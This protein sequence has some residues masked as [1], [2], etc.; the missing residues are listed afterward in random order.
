MKFYNILNLL[1]PRNRP[2]PSVSDSL[3]VY[4]VC[5]SIVVLSGSLSVRSY[6]FLTIL[7]QF[8]LLLVP[9]VYC[10]V[11]SW[12]IKNVLGCTK[13]YVLDLLAGFVLVLGLQ[14]CSWILGSEI[15]R[16]LSGL[17]YAS[18]SLAKIVFDNNPVLAFVLLVILP[19]VCEEVLF[20]GFILSGFSSLTTRGKIV[21]SSVLFSLIHLDPVRICST[22]AAG[23]FLGGRRIKSDSIFTVI[24]MH[25][26]YNSIP[27]FL[28]RL[29]NFSVEKYFD[30]WF[31]KTL[32]F[33][34]GVLL[35]L[36]GVYIFKK[37]SEKKE[38]MSVFKTDTEII[39]P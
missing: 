1:L 3:I 24:W 30:P 9:V 25:F 10:G 34:I 37:S 16:Y 7:I 17:N 29:T 31:M 2:V 28:L 18:V 36:A 22:F 39:A 13:S 35:I 21:L 8:A 32:Y 20:R 6:R 15:L 5:F 19:S 14:F 23:L 27:F 4:I 11:N 38:R 12:S 26:V 33:C